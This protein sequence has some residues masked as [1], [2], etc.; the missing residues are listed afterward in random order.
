MLKITVNPDEKEFSRLKERIPNIERGFSIQM[1]PGKKLLLTGRNRSGK[2]SLL[3][4]IAMSLDCYNQTIDNYWAVNCLKSSGNP[5]P[6][7]FDFEKYDPNTFYR[8]QKDRHLLKELHRPSSHREML[9]DELSKRIKE[10]IEV[11]DV[12]RGIVLLDEPEN[13]MDVDKQNNLSAWFRTMFRHNKYSAI[14]ATNCFHLVYSSLP[15]INLDESPLRMSY[16]DKRVR[17]YERKTKA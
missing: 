12:S 1:E 7:Y 8:T 11:T 6:F 9:D 4:A 17:I 14:I 13:G 16:T 10:F 3:S 15:R 2:S 5:V